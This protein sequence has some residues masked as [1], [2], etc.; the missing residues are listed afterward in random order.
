MAVDGKGVFIALITATL[1]GCSIVGHSS[2]PPPVSSANPAQPVTSPNTVSSEPGGLDPDSLQVQK[3][4][5]R[6]NERMARYSRDYEAALLLGLIYYETRQFDKALAELDR[7]V[8]QAPN[9][10]LAQM[11][12]GD[13]LLSRVAR[14]TGI[15]HNPLLH[16]MPDSRYVLVED[17][18]EE[19]RMRLQAYLSTQNSHK[20][21]AQLLRMGESTETAVL[22]DKHTHRLYL[23]G[24]TGPD[25]PPELLYDF[26]VSTGR[27]KGNKIFKGDLRTPEGVYFVTRYTPA[28]RLPE[29]YGAAAFPINYPNELDRYQR[30]TGGGIWLHGITRRFYSRPPLDSEGCIMLSNP[31]LEQIIPLISPGSTPFIIA[32][33]LEWLEP[34]VWLAR[35]NELI[36]VL[37]AWRHDWESGDAARYLSNYA[38]DFWADGHDFGSWSRMK[39]AALANNGSPQIF[40]SDI[41]LLAYSRNSDV[42]H[43]IVVADFRVDYYSTDNS[44]GKRKRLYL[45]KDQERWQVLH[46]RNI[47]KKSAAM[48][49]IGSTFQ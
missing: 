7:I 12:R 36:Q 41:S 30:K 13:I 32:E 34:D 27:K 2:P 35:K 28:S 48:A 19:A 16:A 44:G 1:C 17:L 24:N 33:R 11:I 9:F 10:H 23:Y 15:G 3:A 6:L 47:M 45:R 49:N 46:E 8:I 42:G 38:A 14:V 37:Q 18:R 22:V 43:E 39:Q 29:K 5:Q 31:D 26:Y 21:P 25:S 40:L 20:L 4:L